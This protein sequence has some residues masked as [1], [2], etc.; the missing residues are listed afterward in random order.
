MASL[1]P[2]IPMIPVIKH[3]RKFTEEELI[4]RKRLHKEE[5]KEQ[6]RVEKELRKLAARQARLKESEEAS[7]APVQVK[8]RVRPPK[9]D[10][11]DAKRLAGRLCSL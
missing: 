5:L 6:R 11:E 4:E 3:K 10:K 2:V 7:K 8:K 1:V 9:A